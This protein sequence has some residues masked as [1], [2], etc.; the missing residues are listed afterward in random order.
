MPTITSRNKSKF[1]KNL[2]NEKLSLLNYLRKLKHSSELLSTLKELL[3]KEEFKNYLLEPAELIAIMAKLPKGDQFEALEHIKNNNDILL[4]AEDIK[5]LKVYLSKE[6]DF[7]QLLASFS[8]LSFK[9]LLSTIGICNL[10][11]RLEKFKALSKQHK[12]CFPIS[13]NFEEFFRLF[14]EKNLLELIRIP[15]VWNK[16]IEINFLSL[17][18][19]SIYPLNQKAA[20]NLLKELYKI[21]FQNFLKKFSVAI[22]KDQINLLLQFQQAK[23]K[24]LIEYLRT[25]QNI[26]ELLRWVPEN[27][28][29]ICLELPSVASA[30]NKMF[31][32]WSDI[33]DMLGYIGNEGVYAFI[34]HL[35]EKNK[36]NGTLDMDQLKILLMGDTFEKRLDF[37]NNLKS[38]QFINSE[39]NPTDSRLIEL[40]PANLDDQLNN[41]LQQQHPLF[42][43]NKAYLH[44][45]SLP[46]IEEEYERYESK[47]LKFGMSI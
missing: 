10:N 41:N 40:F 14:P 27:S 5:K 28:M 24:L 29:L 39:V 9:K 4:S 25:K 21:S 3:I 11:G 37:F 46:S 19:R 43:R 16:L 33:I 12:L 45:F 44:K 6:H 22:E 2:K 38:K 17:S 42:F 15:E 30:I 8:K 1:T 13:A 34:D 35:L 18:K 26:I 31:F 36:I 20:L 7:S 23:P 47:K 32:S